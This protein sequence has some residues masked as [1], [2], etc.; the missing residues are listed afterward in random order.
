MM[1]WILIS[2]IA[3]FIL[4]FFNRKLLSICISVVAG[5][6]LVLAQ[7]DNK[8]NVEFFHNNMWLIILPIFFLLFIF[9][10]LRTFKTFKLLTNKLM[11]W[12]ENVIG[13][14][15]EEVAFSL[16]LIIMVDKNNIESLFI[17]I[18]SSSLIFVNFHIA[19]NEG[20]YS[21]T[22]IVTLFILSVITKVLAIYLSII[23]A[24]M[25]HILYN[26]LVSSFILK[27]KK[28]FKLL[29]GKTI[30][31]NIELN[32]SKNYVITGKNGIGKTTFSKIIGGLL[33]SH[34]DSNEYDIFSQECT[35]NYSV[36]AYK[37]IFDNQKQYD[38]WV[39]E[40]NFGENIHKTF[41]QLSS[42]EK[43]KYKLIL[44][45]MNNPKKVVFDEL[46][47]SL[48]PLAMKAILKALHNYQSKNNISYIFISHNKE[49]VKVFSPELIHFSEKEINYG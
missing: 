27:D 47:N 49:T 36:D 30:K 24:V 39:K 18:I 46:D 28:V 35:Y 12:Y 25:T 21:I 17:I 34:N 26:T 22:E 43:Q 1:I 6:F 44:L 29:N 32:D 10:Y 19:L 42:G 41:E 15:I 45:F 31:N 5:T 20:K 7:K 9:M 8:L 33:F 37:N 11:V 2:S 14:T 13:P 40:L 23:F 38:Y 3:L 4:M 16:L 48:D